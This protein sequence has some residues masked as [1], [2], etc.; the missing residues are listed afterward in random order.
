LPIIYE[1]SA[2]IISTKKLIAR[3]IIDITATVYK[4]PPISKI[5]KVK[6]ERDHTKACQKNPAFGLWIFE[7]NNHF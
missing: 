2:S 7:I 4:M 6:Y 5:L 3:M 1:L